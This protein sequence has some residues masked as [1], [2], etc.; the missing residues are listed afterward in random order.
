MMEKSMDDEK[1]LLQ[2][3]ALIRES[4]PAQPELYEISS[5]MLNLVE[6]LKFSDE[7]WCD[8]ITQHIV[9][10]DSASSFESESASDWDQL[11][12]AVREAFDAIEKLVQSKLSA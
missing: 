8:D 10:L 4:S 3:K 7:K 5:R 11:Q 2:I 9:T 1:V 12:Q 6:A